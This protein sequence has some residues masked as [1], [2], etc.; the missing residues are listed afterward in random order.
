MAPRH[1]ASLNVFKKRQNKKAKKVKKVQEQADEQPKWKNFH[2]VCY[3]IAKLMQCILWL[4]RD[5]VLSTA[6][7]IKTLPRRI[8][9]FF[10][11]ELADHVFHL[12]VCYN[13]WLD[14]S[15]KDA[16][17]SNIRSVLWRPSPRDLHMV[18]D[19]NATGLVFYISLNLT[20]Q[21]WYWRVPS[22]LCSTSPPHATLAYK[23]RFEDY[24]A[25]WDFIFKAKAILLQSSV[26]D[27]W[28]HLSRSNQDGHNKNRFYSIPLTCPGGVIMA[29]IQLL[30]TNMADRNPQNIHLS[31]GWY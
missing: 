4:A 1:P 15:T 9:I 24:T 19:D 25:Y 6:K 12:W 16:H 28:L 29:N 7:I 2:D 11:H 22:S 21:D 5:S 30:L 23:A 13:P 31:I 18:R 27:C 26:E 14:K 3:F 17:M 20:Y 8:T 10:K